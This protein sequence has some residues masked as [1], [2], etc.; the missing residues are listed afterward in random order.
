M[1]IC[2]EKPATSAIT[3]TLV[4]RLGDQLTKY[5]HGKL[6]SYACNIP[7]LY[8]RLSRNGNQFG[9]QFVMDIEEEVRFDEKKARNFKHVINLD[10]NFDYTSI[11]R[12]NE[13]LY[14]VGLNLGKSVPDE[15][16]ND[17]AFRKIIKHRISSRTQL[18]TIFRPKDQI[19]VAVH[20]R[21]GGGFDS[22]L[23]SKAQ[24]ADVRFPLKFPPNQY[25]IDQLK[26]LSKMFDKKPLY[27]HIF[28]D[29][30]NPQRIVNLFKTALKGFKITFATRQ[31]D[32]AHNVNVLDDLFGMAQF[33]CLIRP[34]SSLSIMAQNI[35]DHQVV[36]N[37]IKAH[38]DKKTLIIDEVRVIDNRK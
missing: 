18:Q 36:I 38:W 9:E 29:D 3:Y 14:I 34:Q 22:P 5:Y 15:I 19:T 2:A 12:D 20:V 17:P 8:K 10:S 21:K 28:T 31:K 4:G 1:T 32:N 37:P 6:L 30:K 27:A 7:L 24:F 35:G 23:L 16:K 26:N 25:Y 33:D 11:K 13:T